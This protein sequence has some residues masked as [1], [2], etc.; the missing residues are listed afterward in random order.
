M[1]T[2]DKA[3]YSAQAIILLKVKKL[4]KFKKW[5]VSLGHSHSLGHFSMLYFPL[6]HYRSDSVGELEGFFLR[7]SYYFVLV[8]EIV[9]ILAGFSILKPCC[10]S[11]KHA[12]KVLVDFIF[13]T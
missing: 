9:H 1:V 2:E 8:I 5:S 12:Q 6:F 11:S 10:L 7:L 4:L 13:C 3:L